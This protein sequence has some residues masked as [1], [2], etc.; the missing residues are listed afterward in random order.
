MTTKTIDCIDCGASVPYGRLSCP[1]C[2]GL[3]A[4]VGSRP[5]VAIEATAAV[6]PA[7]E[8]E[9]E[10]FLLPDDEPL[11]PVEWPTHDDPAP[12]LAARPY[13]RLPVDE[14]V[15]GAS[16]TP[17]SSAYRPSTL[18]LSS[19]VAAGPDWSA[20]KAGGASPAPEPAAGGTATMVRSRVGPN[21][22]ARFAEI[23]GW[24]V[25]VGATMAVLGFLLP[26]STA[27]I[28]ARSD[29]GYLDTW[30]LASPTH[31]VVLAATMLI[32]ALGIVR[33]AVPI[34]LRA[35][36]LPLG[37]GSLLIGLAWPYQ[38]GPLGADVGVLVV[39]LGG[40]ALIIGG[41]VAIWVTRHVEIDPVV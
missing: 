3:L 7:P 28:G 10:P 36:V 24:F 40:L 6:E 8:P 39:V 15:A 38:I 19:V 4:S 21:D 41:V 5:A 29:G 16:L 17:R 18:T 23:A 33:T 35:G 32:L 13:Q 12:V 20:P 9:P 25:I 26:W 37:L 11:P 22:P 34:W 31:L 30:G 27:V 14:P 1:E 2:G